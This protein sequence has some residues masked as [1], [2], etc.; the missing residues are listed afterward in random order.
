VA[1]EVAAAAADLS[2]RLKT[3]ASATW[4][5]PLSLTTCPARPAAAVATAAAAA[6]AGQVAS[7]A[8]VAGVAHHLQLWD[9]SL[10][11][12]AT[13]GLCVAG[14]PRLMK[15][16]GEGALGVGVGAQACCCVCSKAK[17]RQHLR[18]QLSHG[19]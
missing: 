18:C 14:P 13:W 7:A 9:L 6:A 11:S 12:C 2:C 19:I 17:D 3:S 10:A 15:A 16:A 1:E 8:H 5:S 4:G